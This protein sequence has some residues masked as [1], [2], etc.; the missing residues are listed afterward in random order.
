MPPRSG[1]HGPGDEHDRLGPLG[2]HLV[3]GHLVVAVDAGRRAQ[4]AEEMDEI[5]GEAVVVIDQREHERGVTLQA[6]APSRIAGNA[7]TL[8]SFGVRKS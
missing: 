1:S 6:P 3:D 8:R 7:Q 5:V 2:Q 4:F